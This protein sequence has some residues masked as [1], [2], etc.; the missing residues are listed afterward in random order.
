VHVWVRTQGEKVLLAMT[1]KPLLSHKR[2]DAASVARLRDTL[3]IYGAGGWKDTDDLRVGDRTQ[4]GVRRAILQETGGLIWW[5]TRLVLGSWF[6]N[7]LEI[8]VALERKD[9]EPLYPIVPLFVDLDPGKQADREAVRAAVGGRGDDF[10]DCNGLVRRRRESRKA[11]HRRVAHR[12]VRDAVKALPVGVGD[13]ATTIPVAMRA[14]GE[15]SGEHDLTFD[16]RTLIDPERR[17]LAPGARE[18]MV[19]ALATARE[20]FQAA[21]PSPSLLLDLDLPLP[22]AFLVGYEWRVTTRLR[23]AVKQRTGSSFVEIEGDGTVANPPDRV[24]ESLAAHGPAV[25]AVSCRDGLGEA[26]AR[27]AAEVDAREL[28]ILHT[29]GL[30]SAPELRGL[31]RACARELRNLSNRSIDKHLL[32]LGPSALAVFAGAAANASGPVTIPFWDGSRYVEPL[33]VGA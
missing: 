25:L 18:L 31:A 33:I 21:F 32:V 8:P 4:E 19:D 22:L 13:A 16:W 1:I 14:L 6:V 23:L 28:V 7:N 12:Y 15:P 11:F 5:G 9:T 20:A 3:K 30:L 17:L 27:Y 29:P 2:E 24:R 10:L 26:A